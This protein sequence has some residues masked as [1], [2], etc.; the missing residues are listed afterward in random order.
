MRIELDD[1]LETKV[2]MDV[3]PFVGRLAE[4]ATQLAQQSAPRV[5]VWNTQFDDRVRPWH[6]SAHE[7][8][9]PDNLRFELDHSPRTYRQYTPP[10]AVAW[11]VRYS[12]ETELL[13]E[14]RDATAHWTQRDACR[15]FLTH[16]DDLA[17]SIGR[18]PV[19]VSATEV[20]C[21]VS[22]SFPRAAESEFG[23][24]EDTPSLFMSAG[25]GSAR[26]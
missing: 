18:G 13:R 14:P 19:V 5:K 23:T 2:A 12:T 11:G 9:V 17:K 22:T 4:M 7:Q 1:D 20:T 3:A 8:A 26:L 10:G 21:E 15:C 6:V 24:A 16:N 25:G